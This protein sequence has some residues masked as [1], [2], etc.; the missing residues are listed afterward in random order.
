[1]EGEEEEEGGGKEK[2]AGMSARAVRRRMF[3]D[4]LKDVQEGMLGVDLNV[5]HATEN[6]GEFVLPMPSAVRTPS[7]TSKHKH[8]HC[9]SSYA[10][11][12]KVHTPLCEPLLLVKRRSLG[13]VPRIQTG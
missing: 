6:E 8:L 2:G 3:K 13:Q 9:C 12:I 10:G 1:M 11:S 4:S 7:L 5:L